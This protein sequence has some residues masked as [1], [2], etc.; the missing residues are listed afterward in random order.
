M[1]TLWAEHEISAPN[2]K[3]PFKNSEQA[4]AEPGPKALPGVGISKRKP[5]HYVGNSDT[6]LDN[7]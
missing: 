1:G 7:L 5:G 3:E 4:P 2:T 6:C